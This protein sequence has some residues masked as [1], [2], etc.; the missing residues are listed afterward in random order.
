MRRNSCKHPLIIGTWNVRSMNLGKLD[1]IKNEMERINIDIL[2]ISEL[3]WTGIG[4]FESDN[5][6]V[7]A[8]NDDSKRNGVAF[9]VKKNVSR[10]ILKYNAVSDRII[11]IRLQGRPVNMAIIQ[12]YAPTTRAKNEE[13]EDFYQLLKS[14]IDQT[15]NQDALII[16]GDWNAKV[17]NEEGSVVGKYGLGDRNNAGD[18]MIGFCKT[19]NFF[20]ANTFFHQ[21]KRRL[22]TWTSLDGTYRNQ[23]DYICGQRQWKRSI[24]SV[25]SGTD[26]QLLICKFKLKLKK[27][28]PQEPNYELEYI[29]PEFRDHL[30]NRF[31]AL[32]ISDRRPDELWNDIIHE[33]SKRSLKRRERNKR[34]RWMSEETLKLALEHRAAKAKGR[35]D[36]VKELNKISKGLSRRQYYNDICKELEMENQ[37]GRTRSAFLKLKELRKKFKPRVAKVKDSMGKILND[38]G[39]IKRR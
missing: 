18:R 28:S 1:I 32:N 39:S 14:E 21:H 20:I 24:L 25:R 16:T 38:A 13:I 3:K 11:S 26:H 7:Y 9:M 10:S 35:V 15:C 37:K 30:K 12:I 29:P 8:G 27:I 34:P 33:E 17:G 6:I 23:I 19:N 2:G 5:H 4:H 22:Y 36:E 31:D